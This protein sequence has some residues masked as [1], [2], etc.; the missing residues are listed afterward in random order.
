MLRILVSDNL[1][2]NALFSRS[3]KSNRNSTGV[4]FIWRRLSKGEYITQCH[5]DSFLITLILCK[6]SVQKDNFTLGI[7]LPFI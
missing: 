5:G 4:C 1:L 3:P 2:M 6:S 7:V